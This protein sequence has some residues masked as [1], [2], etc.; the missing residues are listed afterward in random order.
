[1]DQRTYRHHFEEGRRIAR[2]YAATP[3]QR[4]LA[5]LFV[6]PAVPDAPGG[7]SDRIEYGTAYPVDPGLTQARIN[8]FVHE[9]GLQKEAERDA[10]RSRNRD[11]PRDP[12]GFYH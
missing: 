1:M 11:P 10:T 6:D 5:Q 2:G 7:Y 8:G 12:G 3:V 4:V 9:Q